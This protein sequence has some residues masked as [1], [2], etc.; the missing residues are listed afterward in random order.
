MFKKLVHFETRRPTKV[1]LMFLGPVPISD[2]KYEDLVHLSKFCSKMQA[3]DYFSNLPHNDEARQKRE[4]YSQ[5]RMRTIP[6]SEVAKQ[7]VYLKW[8]SSYTFNK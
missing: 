6:F 4:K 8:H 5:S 3:K 1:L 2:E 7:S